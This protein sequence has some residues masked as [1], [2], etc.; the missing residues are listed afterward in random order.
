[1]RV[2]ID[3]LL[4]VEVF[5]NFRNMCLETYEFDP[6]HFISAPELAW[7]AASKRT[8]EKLDLLVVIDKLLMVARYQK[9]NTSLHLSICRS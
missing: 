1:M 5:E 9:R 8:K 4:L 2:Q 3:T 6:S 7:Q